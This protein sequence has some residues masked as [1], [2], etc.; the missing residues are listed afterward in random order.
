MCPAEENNR[1]HNDSDETMPT[2]KSSPEKAQ[3]RTTVMKKTKFDGRTN[4]D[5]DK[6][7]IDRLNRSRESDSPAHESQIS[8]KIRR[9]KMQL[10]N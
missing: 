3:R 5:F 4:Q 9:A 1:L 6:E 7:R 10:P 2:E 8:F